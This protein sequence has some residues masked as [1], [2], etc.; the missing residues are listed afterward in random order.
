ME[1]EPLRPFVPKAFEMP[2]PER[3]GYRRVKVGKQWKWLPIPKNPLY[4][5]NDSG[6]V[7]RAKRPSASL[8]RK[9]RRAVYVRD[10]FTR[11][12]CGKC[13]GCPDNY[14]GTRN[15]GDLTLDHLVPY[16]D[17]GEFTVENIRA[18]CARCNSSRGARS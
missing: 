6:N 13:H 8:F 11:Y 12:I 17:G 15:I 18:A 2:P 14:D 4:K 7:K 10:K 5:V 3:P 1:A 9:V 16:R